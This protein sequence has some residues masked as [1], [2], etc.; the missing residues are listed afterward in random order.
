MP[1]P[2]GSQPA[3]AAPVPAGPG[4]PAAGG[5]Q[6]SVTPSDSEATILSGARAGPPFATAEERDAFLEREQLTH[7]STLALAALLGETEPALRPQVRSASHGT[8]L[9]ELLAAESLSA[10]T[11]R[12]QPTAKMLALLPALSLQRLEAEKA[13]LAAARKELAERLRPPDDPRTHRLHALLLGLR[14]RVPPQLAPRPLHSLPLERFTQEPQLPG[15]RMVDVRWPVLIPGG[16][17]TPDVRISFGERGPQ[18]ACSCGAAACAH[19]LAALD[20]ALV[21]LRQ[22][23]SA[24]LAAF[25]EE[26]ASPPWERTLKALE[27]AVR[28]RAAPSEEELIFRLSIDER[29]GGI[30][31]A[32]SLRS[33]SGRRS[34]RKLPRD[35]QLPAGLRLS[36]KEERLL[37]LLSP[38]Q[39]PG[40]MLLELVDHPRVFLD[41]EGAAGAPLKIDRAE[42]GLVVQAR[43]QD[44][45]LT[46]GVDGTPLAP[47]VVSRLRAARPEEPAWM[48]H[49]AAR[50]LTPDVRA[51]LS[52]LQKQGALFPPEAKEALLEQLSRLS[53]RVPVALPRS[54]LGTEVPRHDLAVLR[55]ETQAGGQVRLLLRTRPLAESGSC[56][57]GEGPRDVHARRGTEAV[58]TVR[59]LAAELAAA[60]A[61]QDELPLHGAEL[62]E[63]PASQP[64]TFLLP[65]PQAA[66]EVLAAARQRSPVPQLEWDDR[67]LKVYKAQKADALTVSVEKRRDW[68]GVLGGLEVEG[69]RV[70]LARLIE[71]ARRRERFVQVGEGEHTWVEL[72]ARFQ[73]QLEQLADHLHGGR[74]GLETGPSAVAALAALG[75]AGARVE[76]DHAWR[77]LV[78]RVFAAGERRPLVPASLK[79]VLRPYQKEGFAWLSRLASWGAGGVLADDMGLGKTVQA[80]ALLLERARLGPALVVAPASVGFNWAAEAARFAP[81]LR[82]KLLLDEGDRAAALSRLGPRDVLV[83]SYGLLVHDHERLARVRFATCI[84]DEAQ[85]LKNPG[86]LRHR[87]ARA[88]QAEARVALSG[89]PLENALG[90][91]WSVFA[92]VFPVLLGSAESFRVRY[93]APIERAG[94]ERATQALARVLQPFLLRRTK[95]Q[96]AAE[97][98][99]RTEITVPVVLSPAEWQQYEDERLSSLAVL[100]ASKGLRREEERRI[101]VLAALTRLRLRAAHPRLSDPRSTT[102]SAKLERLVELLRELGAEGERALVFSQFTSHLQLVRERLEQEQLAFEQL[103]GQTPTAQRRERVHAFQEGSAPVFLLSLKAGGVGLN[104]TAATS[105][106]LLDPW[107]NPAVE[108]Q[109]ADRAHRLGQTRP[110]SIYRLVAKG[111]IEEKMLGLHARKRALVASVLEGKEGA[112]KLSTQELLQLLAQGPVVEPRRPKLKQ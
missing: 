15:L 5:A 90:E 24:Q 55:F 35:R 18:S 92:A 39:P 71:A 97:L 22:P 102:P 105:V 65:G 16:E 72:E 53:A 100:E 63:T 67:P 54:V 108:D 60:R 32:A 2:T 28:P 103:D 110:V 96:V 44:L 66:L 70:E 59:D 48:W 79:A 45:L 78:A 49:E 93:A 31:V 29:W 26:L 7:L 73:K 62:E 8:L 82:V 94:D 47:E 76:A 80:L 86:T 21:W 23:L 50:V 88:L 11:F 51:A 84:F 83:I 69:A 19:Q 111:T 98:P 112:G 14:A 106:I 95:A 25:I 36:E 6:N 101:E 37:R 85:Q 42:V 17:R 13:A 56:I 40:P 99:P 74:H 68:F 38:G 27:R 1:E 4:A 10:W 52:A 87:A 41:H 12:M 20:T 104:L 77:G 91:L 34:E 43:G 61:L 81:S 57:P 64:F 46:A 30:E 58:H 109:A 107:W 9:V 75:E 3:P 33:R 89:T